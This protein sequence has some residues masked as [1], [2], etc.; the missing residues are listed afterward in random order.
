MCGYGRVQAVSEFFRRI[1][2][3]YRIRFLDFLY[4]KTMPLGQQARVEDSP[5]LSCPECVLN[6]NLGGKTKHANAKP[7]CC[8]P[9][10]HGVAVVLAIA[11]ATVWLGLPVP[12]FEHFLKMNLLF[13]FKKGKTKLHGWDSL[14]H[15]QHGNLQSDVSISRLHCSM[16][17]PLVLC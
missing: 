10:C 7:S 1:R 15:L 11:T 12:F 4:P 16:P 8:V 3:F 2:E 5:L 17:L 14:F 9:Y 13:I 6:C